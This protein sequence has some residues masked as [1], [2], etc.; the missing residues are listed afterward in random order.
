MRGEEAGE[1]VVEVGD[2]LGGGAEGA[3]GKSVWAVGEVE[4]AGFEGGETGAEEFVGGGE[5][6]VWAHGGEAGEEDVWGGLE[7]GGGQGE[8]VFGAEVGE[9][10][11]KRE[12][13]GD[14]EDVEGVFQGMWKGNRGERGGGGR[15]ALGTVVRDQAGEEE[16]AK[17][18]E[19]GLKTVKGGLAEL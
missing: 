12:R 7:P 9:G 1:G 14:E 3:V 13:G 19:K 16:G 2:W 15:G 11:K 4:G 17:G 8:D 5:G 6:V 10:E 18:E